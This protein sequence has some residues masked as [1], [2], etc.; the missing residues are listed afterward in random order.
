MKPLPP[1][2]IELIQR[3][4]ASN[5]KFFKWVQYFSGIIALVAYL[6]DFAQFLSIPV[7]NWLTV[8]NIATVKAGAIT[9]IIMAQLPNQDINEKKMTN[10]IK[11]LIIVVLLIAVVLLAFR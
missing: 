3:I 2:L 11:N 7:P 1:V 4:F 9:A 10:A 8:L 5:P 6:P